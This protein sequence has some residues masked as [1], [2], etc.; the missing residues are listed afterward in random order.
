MAE[1]FETRRHVRRRVEESSL[2]LGVGEGGHRAGKRPSLL[3]ILSLMV[4]F[5]LKRVNFLDC[6][7]AGLIGLVSLVLQQPA[8]QERAPALG[9][10]PVTV[11]QPAYP[12]YLMPARCLQTQARPEC[13]PPPT[14]PPGRAP[15][16]ARCLVETSQVSACVLLPPLE[17]CSGR[18]RLTHQSLRLGRS[19][20]TQSP[21]D[22][23]SL[24][25]SG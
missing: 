22:P 25:S 5:S 23:S 6:D 4:D 19:V 9:K 8:D 20:G 2:L 12:A 11:S 1:E 15:L 24:R 7:Q 21:P 14:P 10:L 18:R 17:Y 16:S 3:P 13:T